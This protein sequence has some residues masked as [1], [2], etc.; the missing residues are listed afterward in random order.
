MSLLDYKNWPW[1]TA[2]ECPLLAF[3]SLQQALFDSASYA[4]G[5]GVK[6]PGVV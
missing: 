6:A 2:L 4:C 1:L 5:S 3:L